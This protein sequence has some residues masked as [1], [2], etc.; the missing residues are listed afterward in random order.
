MQVKFKKGINDFKYLVMFDLA[1]K[2]TGVC[3]WDLQKNE[4]ILTQTLR[5]KGEVELPAA[6]LLDLIIRFFNDL[7]FS[8]GGVSNKDILVMKEAMPTQLRGGSSTVQTFLALARSHCTLDTCMFQNDMAMYDYVGIYPTTWHN[9]F[10]R[11]KGLDKDH[12]VE[13]EEV[14]EYVVSKYKL[15]Q[16]ISMDESDAVFM[17]EAFLNVKWNNDIKEQVLEVKRHRKTLKA[18]HAIKL[19]DEEIERLNG[20]KIVDK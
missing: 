16:N 17:C 5:V 18:P 19:C 7:V 6:E 14:H 20:L 9:Y 11:I 13:K 15:E 8:I 3:L 10:K 1:S 4:P 2:N 12:K